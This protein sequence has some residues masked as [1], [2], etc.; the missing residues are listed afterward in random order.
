MANEWDDDDD[1]FDRPNENESSAFKSLRKAKKDADKALREREE[2]LAALEKRLR[3]VTI[4]DELKERGLN[5]KIAGLIP[6]EVSAESVGDWLTEYSEVLGIAG[7]Q[8]SPEHPEAKAVDPAVA[9]MSRIS[10]ATGSMAPLDNGSEE[11]LAAR[12]RS[13][14]NEQELNQILFGN[15]IGPY[16]M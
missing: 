14:S 16:A 3:E 8:Q 2:K 11:Q 7:T 10:E 9:A 6:S 15:P 5:P 1:E 13:A 12:I 4:K